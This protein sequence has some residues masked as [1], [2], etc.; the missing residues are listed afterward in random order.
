M[1]HEEQELP[2]TE[3]PTPRITAAKIGLF[4]LS[5]LI[6]GVFIFSAITKLY[7]IQYFEYIISSQL[8]IGHQTAAWMARFFIGLEGA[9]GLLLAL[10]IYGYR[11]WVPKACLALLAVFSVH[12]V[13]LL[14]A[15]GNDV[16]C[17]CMGNIAPMTPAQSLLKNAGLILGLLVL[18]RLYRPEDGKILNLATIPVALIIIAVPYF[19]YPAEAAIRMPL[20][21]LYEPAQPEQPATELRNGKHILCFM[22]LGCKH[23]R[24]AAGMMAE[25]KQNNPSLPFYFVLAGGGTDSLRAERL[26][27]FMQETKA[28]NIPHHFLDKED[29]AAM[30][31]QSGSDGVPVILWM[32]DTTVVRKLTIPELNQK[33]TEQWLAQ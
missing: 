25:M 1:E 24:H 33:E 21:K 23:C 2:V 18:L 26:A 29:F 14:L 15:Q 8:H 30:L 9:L 17:G 20:S 22:S 12:L 28:R 6:G 19:L 32:Q 10:N 5:V 13:Y 7:P 4:I 3:P 31:M 11:R 27:D 16:N